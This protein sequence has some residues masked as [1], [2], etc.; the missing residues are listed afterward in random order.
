MRLPSLKRIN[1]TTSRMMDRKYPFTIDNGHGE[2]L[3]FLGRSIKEG[4][5]Y[6]QVENC[7]SAGS[8][9]PLHVHHLQYE[10]VTV[11]EG[12]M[13][14]QAA[15][16]TPQFYGPGEGATFSPG[17]IHRFWNSGDTPLRCEGEIWPPDNVEYFLSEIYRSIRSSSNGRPSAFDAAFLLNRYRTEFDMAEIP[18]FVKRVVFPVILF[19]GKLMGKHKKFSNAPEPIVGNYKI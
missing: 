1:Q 17:T 19:F 10:R 14:A 5:E 13:G 7:V 2:E 3:T 12:N 11:K 18:N 6:L 4:V 9:P 8:G 16:E 15:G